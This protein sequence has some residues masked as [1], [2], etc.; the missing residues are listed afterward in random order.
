MIAS[1]LNQK[2]W[3]DIILV[4]FYSELSFALAAIP[5]WFAHD[6]IYIVLVI[7]ITGVIAALKNLFTADE[8]Q[9]MSNL[10]KDFLS[11]PTDQAVL[12]GVEQLA[13][14]ITN[15][16]GSPVTDPNAPR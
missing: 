9:A 2:Q 5:V 6:P 13:G 3:E 8:S 10:N 4:V 16:S 15:T 1:K 12:A 14:T 7:P 11:D